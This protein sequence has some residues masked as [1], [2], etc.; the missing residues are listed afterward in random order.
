MQ[1][2]NR[3]EREFKEKYEK[4]LK[5]RQGVKMPSNV[6]LEAEL[7]KTNESVASSIS[8]LRYFCTEKIDSMKNTQ[9]AFKRDIEVTVD[10]L[11]KR[12]ANMLQKHKDNDLTN[13]QKLGASAILAVAVV[14]IFLIG[15]MT[16]YNIAAVEEF[17]RN[18]YVMETVKGYNY[19]VWTKKVYIETIDEKE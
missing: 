7:K 6:E 8:D 15:G 13:N 19:P 5:E 18:G 2:K 4:D 10:A 12:C 14:L 16:L 9:Q 17:T 1:D 3:Y 11:D